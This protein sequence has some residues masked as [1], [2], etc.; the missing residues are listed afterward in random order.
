ML[1]EELSNRYLE[2]LC[3]KILNGNGFPMIAD[4]NRR[5]QNSFI[6]NAREN[7]ISFEFFF[8]E[9]IDILCFFTGGD[10]HN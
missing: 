9:K 10:R 3:L 2:A 8:V 6:I 5:F 4:N 1:L 7:E